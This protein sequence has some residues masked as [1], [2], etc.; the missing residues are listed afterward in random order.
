MANSFIHDIRHRLWEGSTLQ[1]LL[2]V[3]IA[4][5]VLIN[6]AKVIMQLFMFS[7]SNYFDITDW[8]AVPASLPTLITRPWTVITYMFLHEEV[9]HILFNMLWLYWMGQ[10]FQEYLGNK[11]LFSTY[12]LGGISGALLYI[13]A[14]NVFPFFSNAVQSAYALG[15]SASVLAI[16]VAAAT[17]LPDY[18]INLL[19]LG[20]IPLKF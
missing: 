2:V 13:I 8:L 18:P 6:A 1:K 4:V 15:A 5:F 20:R 11:K 10:I 16:T 14:F 19:F 7:M 17:L 12:I 3:N 9:F